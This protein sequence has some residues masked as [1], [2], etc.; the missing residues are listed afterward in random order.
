MGSWLLEEG[1]LAVIVEIKS[2][3]TRS[4]WSKTTVQKAFARAFNTA[5]AQA[6]RQA[7]YHFKAPSTSETAEVIG[8]ACVAEWWAWT[9]LSRD[10][11]PELS[12]YIDKTFHPDYEES[13]PD[14]PDPDTLPRTPKK[15]KG[16]KRAMPD[17]DEK[18]NP[19]EWSLWLPNVYVDST[20]TDL[21]ADR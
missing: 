8:I 1:V 15:G 9:L 20:F 7:R 21:I 13:E 12:D 17:S 4:N 16:K 11:V 2:L 5:T 14:E 18:T 19:E 3:Q 6:E 10:N